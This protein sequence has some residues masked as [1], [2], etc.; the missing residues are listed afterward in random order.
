[1]NARATLWGALALVG[2][3]T[4]SATAQIAGS[5]HDFSSMAWSGGQICK[6]CHIP[7]NAIPGMDRL[8]NHQLTTATYTMHGGTGTAEADFDYRSRLCLSC[9]DGTVALDSFGGTTGSSFI[10]GR[11]NLGTDLTNDH[12]VGADAEYPPI[13]QPSWWAGAFK[14]ESALPTSIRLQNWTDAAG[15][16][17]KVVGCT[18]CHNP[19]NR[20]NY[21]HMLVMS[22]TASAVCLGCHIK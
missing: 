14:A 17:Y 8:W 20:G 1:M 21:G 13:P 12:P 10:G 18:S 4:S 16:A 19:H 9:H 2:L 15:T 5:A 6:P 22:N 7:H 3:A 11:R